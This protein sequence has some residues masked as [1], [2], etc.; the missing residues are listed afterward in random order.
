MVDFIGYI[1][2]YIYVDVALSVIFKQPDVML[3][4]SAIWKEFGH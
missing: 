2:Q 4:I 1:I 3:N